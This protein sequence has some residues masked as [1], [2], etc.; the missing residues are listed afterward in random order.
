ENKFLKRPP[1]KIDRE[2]HTVDDLDLCPEAAGQ[3]NLRRAAAALPREGEEEAV[4]RAHRQAGEARVVREA[5]FDTRVTQGRG[6]ELLQVPGGPDPV[7]PRRADAG[8]GRR[9]GPAQVEVPPEALPAG[10]KEKLLAPA[11][12]KTFGRKALVHVP[13]A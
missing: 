3:V 2:H 10:S 13:V 4:V 5:E 12:M 1:A 7:P 11:P 8:H 6:L 9:V